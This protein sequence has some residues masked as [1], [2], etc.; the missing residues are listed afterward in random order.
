MDH[1]I[2][3]KTVK[4]ILNSPAPKVGRNHQTQTQQQPN[5]KAR[6]IDQIE[7]GPQASQRQAAPQLPKNVPAL[8]DQQMSVIQDVESIEERSRKGWGPGGVPYDNSPKF[9][10]TQ[11]K[12]LKVWDDMD[13]SDNRGWNR[14]RHMGYADMLRIEYTLKNIEAEKKAMNQTVLTRDDIKSALNQ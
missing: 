12:A 10:E 5:L 13:R 3:N 2:M 14:S 8:T 9:N 4:K 11:L 6:L 1:L 7:N